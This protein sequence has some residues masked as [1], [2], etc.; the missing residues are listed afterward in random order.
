M[1]SIMNAALNSQG[2]DE[3]ASVNDGSVEYL[4]LARNWPLIVEAE[5]EDGLY[6]FTRQQ[7]QLL[8]R[9]DGKFGFN[10]GYML[11]GD[12]LTVRDLWILDNGERIERDWTQDNQYVYLDNASG[13]YIEYLVAASE[14]LWTANFA[15]GVQMKLEAVLLRAVKEEYGEAREMEQQAEVYFQRARTQ[16]SKARSATPPYKL[17]AIAEA[18]HRGRMRYPSGTS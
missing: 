16:S 12:C 9:T 1:L 8:T 7:T 6:H 17:G 11:P 14:S 5:L 15:R 10:D 4:V 13:C 18:R 2:L 3:I